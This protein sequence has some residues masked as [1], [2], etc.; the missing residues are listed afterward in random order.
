[1]TA[2]TINNYKISNDLSVCLHVLLSENVSLSIL[3]SSSPPSSP[4]FI[5]SHIN[6]PSFP[7]R[8]M[9]QLHLYY[10]V[11]ISMASRSVLLR[12]A[13]DRQETGPRWLNLSGSAC[14]SG[15]AAAHRQEL[16]CWDTTFRKIG[17]SK[18]NAAD[19]G[20]QLILYWCCVFTDMYL[21]SFD[22]KLWCQTKD[23]IRNNVK[24]R[25]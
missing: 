14:S 15:C 6:T 1:M 17:V 4:V 23:L 10:K 21:S 3:S 9:C 25:K 2:K 20:T 13:C 11:S 22:A 19:S 18:K 16:L 7:P 12:W 5:F 24:K 8:Y